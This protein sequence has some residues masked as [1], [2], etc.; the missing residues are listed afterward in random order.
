M[1]CTFKSGGVYTQYETRSSRGASDA[2]IGWN[3]APV[4]R[5]SSVSTRWQ[6]SRD[7]KLTAISITMEVTLFRLWHE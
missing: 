4:Q 5:G 1:M 6:P 7:E 2:R 3:A